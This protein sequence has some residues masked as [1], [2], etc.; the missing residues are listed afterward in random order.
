MNQT[1][2]SK[3][4]EM[5]MK[6]QKEEHDGRLA[7]VM[8]LKSKSEMARKLEVLKIAAKESMSKLERLKSKEH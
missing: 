4:E 8:K 1:N 5:R 7:E 2:M 6:R 3:F